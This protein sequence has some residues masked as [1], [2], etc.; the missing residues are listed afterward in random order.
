MKLDLR[1]SERPVESLWCQAIAALVPQRTFLA[2]GVLASLDAKLGGFL[3]R[4][5][6]KGFWTGEYGENLL[7]ASQ[8]MIKADKILLAGLG[9][10]ESCSLECVVGRAAEV[11]SALVKLR[12]QDLGVHIPVMEGREQEYPECVEDSVRAIVGPYISAHGDEAD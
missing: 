11:G 4:L 1:F 10:S 5:E 7:V 9:P 6:E 3:A 12:A 2:Q 8:G